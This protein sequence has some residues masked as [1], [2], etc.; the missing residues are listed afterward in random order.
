MIKLPFDAYMFEMVFI[1]PDAIGSGP[2]F[3]VGSSTKTSLIVDN[4]GWVGIGTSSPDTMFTVA[5]QSTAVYY[6]VTGLS[7][8]TT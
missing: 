4:K 5:G 8:G 2:A 1:N 6:N 3:V 7:V